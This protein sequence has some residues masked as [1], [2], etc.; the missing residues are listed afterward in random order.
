MKKVIV[1]RTSDDG[2]IA[3]ASTKKRAWEIIKDYAGAYYDKVT[4]QFSENP[5]KPLNYNS[6]CKIMRE[7][8]FQG[9]GAD[10]DADGT[11][12]EAYWFT[13]NKF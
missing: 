7:N 8:D 3:V 6:F 1:I 13:V 12:I 4:D 2:V 11:S 9:S 5:S 10:L